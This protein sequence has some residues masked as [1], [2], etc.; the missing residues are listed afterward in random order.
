MDSGSSVSIIS[1]ATLSKL[2]LK[3]I[4]IDGPKVSGIAGE[5]TK[6]KACV[7]TNVAFDGQIT[8]TRFLVHQSFTF[9][10]LLGLDYLRNSCAR[11]VFNKRQIKVDNNDHCCSMAD[12]IGDEYFEEQDTPDDCLYAAFTT[13]IPP[14]SCIP[15]KVV[16]DPS[17]NGGALIEPVERRSQPYYSYPAL[18]SIKDGHSIVLVVNPTSDSVPVY[19]DSVLAKFAAEEN[20]K[21]KVETVRPQ[22][23][24]KLT[25]EEQRRLNDI[26]SKTSRLF[27]ARTDYGGIKSAPMHIPL[28]D[29]AVPQS[30][31]PYQ[32]SPKDRIL[33]NSQVLEMLKLGVIRPS[34]SAF[35]SPVFVIKKRDGG[36]RFV[37]DLRSLNAITVPDRYPLPRISDILDSLSKAKYYSICDMSAAYWQVKIDEESKHRTAFITTEGLFE[38]QVVPFG[39]RNAP[40]FFQRMMDQI[41][42]PFKWKNC[43][44]YLDDIIIFSETFEQH[45][46]DVEQVFT[47]LNDHNIRL[48]GKKTFLGQTRIKFLGHTIT[49][50]GIKPDPSN[51]IPIS[52][53]KTPTSVKMLRSFLG[54]VSYYRRF[55]PTFSTE[56]APLYELLKKENKFTWSIDCQ[57]AF[58]SF[59]QKLT[60][61]PIVAHFKDDCPT[62]IQTDASIEGIGAVLEQQQ[63]GEWRLIACVSRSTNDAEKKYHIQELESLALVYSIDK[64][65]VYLHGRP[66]TAIIDNHSLCWL[67]S[68]KKCSAKIVRWRFILSE[69][70]FDIVHQKGKDNC[71]ADCLS[72]WP[73]PFNPATQ[74]DEFPIFFVSREKLNEEQWNDPWIKKC[75]TDFF[76]NNITYSFKDKCW[77][78]E[79]RGKQGPTYQIVIPKSL[80]EEC[81]KHFHDSPDDGGHWS[82]IRMFDKIRSRFFWPNMERDIKLF[83]K[84]CEICQFRNSRRS[85]KIGNLQSNYSE[86]PF[87]RWAVDVIGPLPKTKKKNVYIITMID[88]FTKWA[89]ARAVPDQKSHRVIDF[90]KDTFNRFGYPK[91]LIHDQGSN[92]MGRETQE[93]LNN[94]SIRSCNTSGYR[95]MSNGMVERFNR[96]LTIY[97]SKFCNKNK[98]NWD[99]LLTNAL[100]SY[101]KSIQKSTGKS[102]YT[103]VYSTHPK[104][105]VD[106]TLP[107]IIEEDQ[108]IETIRKMV[109]DNIRKCHEESKKRYDKS[110]KE[111]DFKVGDE[112]LVAP[113]SLH[114][115]IHKLELK[116]YTGPFE[117][118]K[119]VSPVNYRIKL[120]ESDQK[121]F[122]IHVDRLK[123]FFRREGQKKSSDES[124]EKPV[125]NLSKYTFHEDNSTEFYYVRTMDEE[126]DVSDSGSERSLP[127]LSPP[128][129]PDTPSPTRSP[130]EKLEERKETLPPTILSNQMAP[131]RETIETPKLLR[132]STSVESSP[133]ETWPRQLQIGQAIKKNSPPR[134]PVPK[135][136]PKPDLNVLEF[137]RDDIVEI[138][139]PVE[140]ISN[141]ARNLMSRF[142][143]FN[144]LTAPMLTPPRPE[145]ALIPNLDE[146]LVDISGQSAA[147]PLI[148]GLP[149]MPP[150][151]P[152]PAAASTFVRSSSTSVLVPSSSSSHIQQQRRNIPVR[153]TS[154]S[155]SDLTRIPTQAQPISSTSQS[156]S[157]IVADSTKRV[158]K[159]VKKL[160]IKTTKG[161][162]YDQ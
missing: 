71:V 10:I 24:N 98:K 36:S 154:V 62:R 14:R 145:S 49:K 9:P 35:A 67:K 95:P 3:Q 105:V 123:K 20:R 115:K 150:L 113:T 54:M 19:R 15:I 70:E 32:R 94:S 92:F 109:A 101:N 27:E 84:T 60:T 25:P 59:K 149:P 160:D 153:S 82:F 81:M 46:K 128:L 5:R 104:S 143:P 63:D 108:D 90:L 132:P 122:T 2:N 152:I 52:N 129:P 72:R 28:I 23:N 21:T 12:I 64:F 120:K 69:F 47:K 140:S 73:E 75:T 79:S 33:I 93:F 77:Y 74:R 56:A 119:K 16:C 117:L 78:R 116:H 51:L 30:H 1:P 22:I 161:K 65:R 157:H 130:S 148:P 158:S 41:L 34:N 11:I 53:F 159:P 43:L 110:V 83:I 147:R 114:P 13:V 88:L 7:D 138:P 141:Q 89:E 29:G 39:F 133:T 87:E 61:E 107:T 139:T 112:A 85:N 124:K 146:M 106:R 55:I 58:E 45:L 8:K 26:V 31:P 80:R 102:P 125:S 48:N 99:E 137:E 18:V 126:S 121:P 118:L 91:D 103:I 144:V 68:L 134:P 155:S 76:N 96:T 151:V 42:S 127:P 86:G 17:T 162:S 131:R 50:D 135:I 97:L 6:I 100:A 38:F 111:V 37:V 57:K 4:P 44:V 136:P 156:Q 66:F 40:A 142:N